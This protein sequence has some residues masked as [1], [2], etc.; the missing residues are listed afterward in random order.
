ME[1]SKHVVE[2]GK[3]L[4]SKFETECSDEIRFASWNYIWTKISAEDDWNDINKEINKIVEG[5]VISRESVKL[6][7]Y[8]IKLLAKIDLSRDNWKTNVKDRLIVR[9]LCLAAFVHHTLGKYPVEVFST[10]VALF[11][12]FLSK[13][14]NKQKS[15]QFNHFRSSSGFEP[16]ELFSGFELQYKSIP[17][18][19]R[20]FL[21]SYFE[22]LGGE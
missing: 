9:R 11:N 3:S 5:V 17:Q 14:L 16:I 19:E 6:N 4:L 18:E 21:E 8:K 20:S 7:Y 22:S 10:P 15:T 2:S 13:I 1:A 12:N